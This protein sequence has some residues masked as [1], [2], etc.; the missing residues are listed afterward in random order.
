[1][2]DKKSIQQPLLHKISPRFDSRKLAHKTSQ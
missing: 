2:S 1:V